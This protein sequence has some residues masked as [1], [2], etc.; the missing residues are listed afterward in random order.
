MTKPSKS[1][2]FRRAWQIVHVTRTT[3]TNWTFSAALKLAW[4]ELK[5]ETTWHWPVAPI[6]A[7]DAVSLARAEVQAATD[8]RIVAENNDCRHG[9]KLIGPARAAEDAAR[10]KLATLMNA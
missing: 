3:G 4:R 6:K 9:W 7:P 5:N 8:A 2:L 1:D 10:A